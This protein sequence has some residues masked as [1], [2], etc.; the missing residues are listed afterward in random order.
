METEAINNGILYVCSE[1]VMHRE[2]L[3]RDYYS[4]CDDREHFTQEIYVQS[5]YILAYSTAKAYRIY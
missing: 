2:S 4:F 3:C 1:I 5:I